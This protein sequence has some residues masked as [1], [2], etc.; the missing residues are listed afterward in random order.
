M[1]RHSFVLVH[2]A[3][4]GAWA[5]LPIVQRLQ[6]LGY[7]ATAVELPGRGSHPAAIRSITLELHIEHVLKVLNRHKR[8]V[9]LVGHGMAGMVI[10]GVAERLPQ[11]VAQLVYVAAFMLPSGDSILSRMQVDPHTEMLSSI[12]YS[13]DQSYTDLDTETARQCLYNSCS[14][15]A[16]NEGVEA[17]VPEAT[18]PLITPLK[19]SDNNFGTV[20]RTYVRCLR[21]RIVSPQTQSELI[22]TLPCR[23]VFDVEAD[24]TPFLSA[25]DALLRSLLEVAAQAD[26][27]AA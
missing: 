23:K 7:S 4:L 12:R 1:S 6:D 3:W 26:T 17:L 18:R 24:H 5:W 2:G 15:K 27:R 10:S 22:G 13:D 20:P 21:D 16:L 14:D 11:R 8:P 25:P 19:L 9:I